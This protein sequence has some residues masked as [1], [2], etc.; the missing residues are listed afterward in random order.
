MKIGIIGCGNM[1]SAIARRLS[2][3]HQLYLY[4]HQR[5][6]S[7]HLEEQRCGNACKS[8]AHAISSSEILILAVKPQNLTSVAAEIKNS[9]QENKVIVSLLAGTTLATLKHYFP[10]VHVTR[11]MP[12]LALTQGEGVIGL[13]S[14]EGLK[15]EVKESLFKIFKQLGKVYWI[16]EEKMDALT[17]LTGSGPAFFFA[18]VEAMIEAGI[19]LGFT[20]DEAQDLVYQMLHGSLS[21]LEQSGEHPAALRWQIASPQGTTI[22][23]LRKFE[24]F[25]TRAGVMNAFIAAYEWSCKLSMRHKNESNL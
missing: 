20:S 23:G 15:N 11:M 25:A 1:G 5:E 21:L 12:N 24:E 6:K 14:D 3:E 9:L 2:N 13:C 7:R 16:S 22:A 10:N 17:A 18:I 8:L 4:D 19:A